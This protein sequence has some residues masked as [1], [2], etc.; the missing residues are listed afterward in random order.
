MPRPLLEDKELKDMVVT[1]LQKLK[2]NFLLGSVRFMPPAAYN[3]AMLFNEKG[4]FKLYDKQ[5]LVPFGEYVP[6]RN[7]FPLF[8][9]IVG[10]EVPSD[11]DAGTESVVMD[12]DRKPYKIGPLICFEDT[13]GDLTRKFAR[14]GAELLVT[15]TN[16]GWFRESAGSRQHLANAVLRSAETKLPLVRA[17]NTGVTCFVNRFG[18]VTHMLASNGNTFIEGVLYGTIPIRLQPPKTFYTQYGDLFA[19]LCLFGALLSIRT[20][21]LTARRPGLS[22]N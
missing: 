5:H 3:S 15:I 12:L 19:M 6:F 10:S 8:A 2:T 13:L 18:A 16:D 17:A 21:L 20:Q 7:T 4:G 14:A 9:W 1:I 22:E 11:F